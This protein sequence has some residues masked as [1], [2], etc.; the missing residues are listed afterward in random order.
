MNIE[1]IDQK[2][3]ERFLL[4]KRASQTILSYNTKNNRCMGQTH[5]QPFSFKTNFW[6]S[7]NWEKILFKTPIITHNVNT[8]FLQTPP[9][10]SLDPGRKQALEG[11]D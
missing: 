1:T 2:I 4:F 7:L 11:P 10:L 8:Y 3:C 9:K 6:I 5:F